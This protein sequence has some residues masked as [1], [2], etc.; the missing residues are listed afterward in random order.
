M[1]G[2]VTPGADAQQG[3]A[4]DDPVIRAL[5]ERS[6]YIGVAAWSEPSLVELY[7]RTAKTPEQRLRH[8]ATQFAVTEVDSTFYHPLAERAHRGA[9]GGTDATRLPLRR[10]GLS[11]AHPP[12][13]AAR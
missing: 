5:A 1:V 8:Y 10:E 2:G 11:P 7:P 6:L 4:V 12:S 9:V 13:D 3:V